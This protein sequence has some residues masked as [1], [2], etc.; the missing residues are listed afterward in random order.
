MASGSWQS[1]NPAYS[2]V[3]LVVSAIAILVAF[4]LILVH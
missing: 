1:R 4:A 3:A 2:Y